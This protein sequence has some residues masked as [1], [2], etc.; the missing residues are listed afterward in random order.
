MVPSFVPWLMVV[1]GVALGVSYVLRAFRVG[2]NADAFTAVVRKLL[3]AAN[4][5]RVIKLTRAAPD[6][7]L[8]AAARAA[9]V[10]CARGL[11][12]G[13]P[14]ADYRRAG[15]LSS[16]HV[17]APVRAAWDAAFEALARPVRVARY[18]A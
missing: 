4:A 13:D 17:L 10:A 1:T 15:D 3:D 6:S 2:L 14:A 7:P 16:D 18:A 9:V 8:A 11:P 5:D 12:Q